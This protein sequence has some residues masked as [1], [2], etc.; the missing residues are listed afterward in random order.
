M[1]SIHLTGKK[2]VT[3][4]PEMTPRD[5]MV[6]MYKR[7]DQASLHKVG[8]APKTELSE[9]AIPNVQQFSLLQR[10]RQGRDF[11]EFDKAKID[12]YKKQYEL[13]Q[14]LDGTNENTNIHM[15]SNV[16]KESDQK[17]WLE[18]DPATKQ[19]NIQK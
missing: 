9:A 19:R 3:E 13:D 2:F 1:S 11:K 18:Q 7:I 6:N 8:L 12:M 5:K 4:E 14:D 10:F 17:F 15:N 16:D